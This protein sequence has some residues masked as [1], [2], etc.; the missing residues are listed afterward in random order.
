M[1]ADPR[2]RAYYRAPRPRHPCPT[3]TCPHCCRTRR[4]VR[5]RSRGT[6]SPYMV[7]RRMHYLQLPADTRRV[8]VWF[9]CGHRQRIITN[10]LET[11]ELSI[12]KNGCAQPWS[13][14]GDE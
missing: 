2:A 4:I 9:S 11:L 6:T 7:G 12:D 10:Q 14:D 3:A 8:D 1:T 5:A 13:K